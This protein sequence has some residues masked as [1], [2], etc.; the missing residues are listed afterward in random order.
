[1][2]V[3]LLSWLLVFSAQAG[4][5]ITIIEAPATK[6]WSHW[7]TSS[8]TNVT[9]LIEILQRSETGRGLIR[10]A[11]AKAAQSGMLL[12][13]V[14]QPGEGSLTDTTLIR[15]FY[16]ENPDQVVFET[17][18]KVFVNRHLAWREA[19]LDLAHEL[20]HYVHREPFNPYTV[21]FS[22]ADFVT[23]TIESRGGEVHAFVTECHVMK[24]LF[25]QEFTQDS[26]CNKIS[27][28]SGKLSTPKAVE[29]FYHVGGFFPQMKKILDDRG[30]T[31]HF[32][33]LKQEKTKFVSSAY[34]LPYPLAAVA[35][36]QTVLSKVCEN[37]R[38]RLGFM[39]KD[40][41][42]ASVEKFR[43]NLEQRCRTVTQN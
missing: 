18:A 16:P 25:T 42:P 26:N 29:L 14:I 41:S 32:P 9:R 21:N 15:K 28:P 33:H 23:S 10:S 38:R 27:E 24:E 1:M 37:D 36:Y 17:R 40:R 13:D 4:P 31:N 11:S 3:L 12:T 20:T 5:E 34:G 2:A 39:K 30:I 35:E 7:T 22:L 19:L 6:V 43:L 8:Q